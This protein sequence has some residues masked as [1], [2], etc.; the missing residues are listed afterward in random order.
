MA[1][2]LYISRL[3]DQNNGYLFVDFENKSLDVAYL[4][5]INFKKW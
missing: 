4:S 5:L 3:V 2:K 1:R